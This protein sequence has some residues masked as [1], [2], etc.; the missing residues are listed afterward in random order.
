MIR[1]QPRARIKGT[2][3]RIMCQAEDRL[4]A[5]IALNVSTGKSAIPATCWIPALLTTMSTL[6]VAAAAR[7]TIAAISSGRAMSA[8]S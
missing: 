6:P 3:A 5:M 7:L 1:P 4:I 8:A 2:A